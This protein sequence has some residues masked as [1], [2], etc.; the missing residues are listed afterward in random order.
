MVT[1]TFSD[2]FNDMISP[3]NKAFVGSTASVEIQI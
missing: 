1:T 3:D 2:E